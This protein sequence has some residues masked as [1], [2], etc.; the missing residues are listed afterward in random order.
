LA[1]EEDE[2]LESNRKM[3]AEWAEVQKELLI[4]SRKKYGTKLAVQLY[5]PFILSFQGD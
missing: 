4:E 5:G 3:L 2:A 1:K